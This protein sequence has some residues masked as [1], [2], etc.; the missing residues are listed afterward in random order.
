MNC[1]GGFNIQADPDVAGIGVIVAFLITA[2]F[3][4]VLALLAF[5]FVDDAVPE[6]ALHPLDDLVIKIA[7]KPFL[8]DGRLP[9]TMNRELLQK[10]CMMLGDQQ[11]VTGAAIL[12][13][14]FSTRS[15]IT[16]YHFIIG[17]SLGFAS[18]ATFQATALAAGE[19]VRDNNLKKGWRFPWYCL[20]V[21]GVT[22][23]NYVYLDENF[24]VYDHWGLPT[25]CVLDV[26]GTYTADSIVR[27]VFWTV[28]SADG[29]MS[30]AKFFWP[31]LRIIE[32]YREI[33]FLLPF[34]PLQAI[35]LINKTFIQAKSGHGKL[36]RCIGFILQA[37]LIVSFWICFAVF[38]IY[39]S[40]NF[41]LFRCFLILVLTTWGVYGIRIEARLYYLEGNEDKWGFGQILPL[42][43]LALP[44]FQSFETY[45][46][47]EDPPTIESKDAKDDHGKTETER[48]NKTQV[49]SGERSMSAPAS[50][51]NTVITSQTVTAASDRPRAS[52]SSERITTT[53][54]GQSV[55]NSPAS[56]ASSA[57]KPAHDQSI[58]RITRQLTKLAAVSDDL[59]SGQDGGERAP[60]LGRKARN[61]FLRI[62]YQDKL[63]IQEIQMLLYNT[64]RIVAPFNCFMLFVMV[65]SY[66]LVT[67]VCFRYDFV[68]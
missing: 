1:S 39:D 38:D 49:L 44:L 67:W 53:Q 29:M 33:S 63:S 40:I 64:D 41:D 17:T 32:F 54:P 21:V 12:I 13:V 9:W 43:L 37:P 15:D 18:F 11:L 7:R 25:Q 6:D 59:E 2:W 45:F 34:I 61:I 62:L 55:E 24:L 20:I 42:L 22:F 51:I 31:T 8:R 19:L 60:A 28:I 65:A 36:R 57:R 16:Q 66:T 68:L 30:M 47:S 58:Q 26:L 14:C 52:T 10:V 50:P 35:S 23:C 48:S 56:A 27:L 4:F 46:G 5:F 3:S